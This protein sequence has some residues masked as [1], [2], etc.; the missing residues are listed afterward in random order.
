MREIT[1]NLNKNL[2]EKIASKNPLIEKNMI[3]AYKKNINEGDIIKFIS[4]SGKFLARGYYGIQN[5]G[6]GWILSY[7]FKEKI[8]DKFFKKIINRAISGRN[9]L[10]KDINTNAYRIFNAEGD[11]IGGL[12]I[13]LYSDNVLI[14]WYSKGIYTY[15]DIIV[16][17]LKKRLPSMSI[18]EKRRFGESGKYISGKDFIC[19]HYP[20]EPTVIMQDG[21]KYIVNLDDGAMTGLFLDQ[22][23]VRN[24]LKNSYSKGKSVLN[25]FSYTGAFGVA[26][27]L[28]GAKSTVNVDIAKRSFEL[29]KQNYEINNLEFS[30]K[31]VFI[32]DVFEYIKFSIKKGNKWDVIIFDPPSFS[33][34]KG[35]KFQVERDYMNLIKDVL[36]LLSN[37][38][39]LIASTNYAKW[40][41]EQFI[42]NIGDVIKSSN[43]SINILETYSLSDDFKT[44]SK[45]PESD[46]LKVVVLESLL[47]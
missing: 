18:F 35:N 19:G 5:K 30:D 27:K 14:Q 12:S 17:I 1:I 41:K 38:G 33:R 16:N 4:E 10:H 13:D 6:Y 15:R 44:H 37:K 26:A 46:Y 24:K 9:N 2:E 25:L 29:T 11:G 40:T 32:G 8:D 20:T 3:K 34:S 47:T 7:S 43:L 31:E 28:G 42:N 36:K 22:R 39:I 45:Y 21:I 23:M